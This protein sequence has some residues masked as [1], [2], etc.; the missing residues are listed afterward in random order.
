MQAIPAYMNDTRVRAPDCCSAGFKLIQKPPNRITKNPTKD[1]FFLTNKS[2]WTLKF[3]LRQSNTASETTLMQK[4]GEVQL[5][6]AIFATAGTA[7]GVWRFVFMYSE[8]H[9]LAITVFLSRCWNRKRR[10]PTLSLGEVE[11]QCSKE[12]TGASIIECPTDPTGNEDTASEEKNSRLEKELKE[13]VNRLERE[14][15]ERIIRSE[16]EIKDLKTDVSL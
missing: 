12:S 11:M 6:S 5:L 4:Q 15:T 1:P 16:R 14:L 9:I 2:V 8:A 13:M 7:L 10:G 3:E